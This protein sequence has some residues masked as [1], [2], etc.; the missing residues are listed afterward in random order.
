MMIDD[1]PSMK[2]VHINVR[3]QVIIYTDLHFCMAKA[4]HVPAFNAF[5]R[6]AKL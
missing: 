4:F 6:L 5:Y 3:A 1:E 2:R